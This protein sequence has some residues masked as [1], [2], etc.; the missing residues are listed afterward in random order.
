[1][2][3]IINLIMEKKL[4]ESISFWVI[5]LIYILCSVRY[6]PDN[7]LKTLLKS[8]MQILEV[9]PLT[10]GGTIIIVS[11]MQRVLGEKLPWDRVVR[12]FLT[13][14]IIIEILYGLYIYLG[15]K[16]I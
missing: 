7:P 3:E 10:I 12:I 5:I 9:A 14:G 15:V 13:L 16:G 2:S 11:L 8:I 4:K 1:M 6:Y